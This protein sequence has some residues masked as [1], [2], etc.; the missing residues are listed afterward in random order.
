MRLRA[1]VIILI[2]IGLGACSTGPRHSV[3]PSHEA[4]QA[5]TDAGR[6]AF[7]RGQY[8]EAEQLF[9]QA[10]TQAEAFGPADA[11]LATSLNNVATV[12]RIRKRYPEAE[13]LD[14]R[15]LSIQEQTLGSN[16][17]FVATTLL[18]IA[19]SCRAQARYA[20]A[21]AAATRAMSIRAAALG[22]DHVDVAAATYNL[23]LTYAAE[24]RYD[25]AAPLF[26]RV[27]AIYER[28][29]GPQ[30]PRLAWVLDSYA[31]LLR[32]SPRASEARALEQR[33]ASIR[34]AQ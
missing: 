27:I 20:D 30:D 12:D 13:S 22:P 29:L 16:H 21:A 5:R 1:S 25:D 8:D 11:R 15:A 17:L 33:A 28:S 31:A 4:W 14:R 18:G 19:D 2:A 7:E 32:H 10:L 9:N 6:V 26:E 23:G 3:D 24:N 34:A